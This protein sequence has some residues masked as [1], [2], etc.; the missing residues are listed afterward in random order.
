MLLPHGSS[1]GPRSSPGGICGFLSRT[2]LTRS[3]C[4]HVRA[5]VACHSPVRSALSAPSQAGTAAPDTTH[6]GQHSD[7]TSWGGVLPAL[8]QLANT[9]TSLQCACS[10]LNTRAACRLGPQAQCKAWIPARHG[11]RLL[12]AFPKSHGLPLLLILHSTKHNFNPT[13]HCLVHWYWF[14]S[15]D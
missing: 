10:W 5:A 7:P 13:H 2:G 11:T 1:D 8:R 15:S 6:T 14:Y 4:R 12:Q 3:L 9:E